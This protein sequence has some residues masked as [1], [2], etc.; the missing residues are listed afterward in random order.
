MTAHLQGPR[1]SVSLRVD[2]PPG[3]RGTGDPCLAPRVLVVDDSLVARKA[4]RAILSQGGGI[5]VLE[6]RDGRQALE[7]L[8]RDRPALVVTD[9]QMPDLDGLDLL[10]LMKQDYPEV[11]AIVM[12]AHGT[13]RYAIEALRLGAANYI[14]KGDLAADLVRTVGRVLDLLKSRDRRLHVRRFLACRESRFEVPSDPGLIQQL[15]EVLLEDFDA[16]GSRD[17]GVR[18]RVGVALTEALTNAIYHGNLEVSSDLRQED[19]RHFYA[20]AQRRREMPPYGG[21]LVHIDVHVGPDGAAFEIEDEGPGFDTSTLYR[22]I[23]EEDLLRVGGRG[24]LL[25]R[26]FMDEVRHNSLGNRITMIKRF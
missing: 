22:P 16:A 20:L 17:P 25:V 18:V 6:A 23:T 1:R 9:L 7:V 3:P 14:P 24:M 21:R 4:A 13:E 15:V 26:E 10:A 5:E 12:T 19:E 11:P 2:T 8:R